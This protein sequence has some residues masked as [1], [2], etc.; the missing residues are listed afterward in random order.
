MARKY[1]RDNRGRFASVGATARGSR[2]KTAGGNKRKSQTI[3]SKASRAGTIG[4]PKGLKPN[5]IK[6][7]QEA[8]AFSKVQFDHAAFMRRSIR[9]DT[10]AGIREAY[11]KQGGRKP[12]ALEAKKIARAKD[13]AARARKFDSTPTRDRVVRSTAAKPATKKTKARSKVSDAKISRVINRVNSVVRG[14]DTKS[15]VKRMNAVE[16]GQRAKSFLARKAGGVSAINGMGQAE[17]FASV[18]KAMTKPPRYS[19]TNPNRNKPGAYNNLGQSSARAKARA[20]AMTPQQR[21][22]QS[23]AAKVKPASVASRAGIGSRALK[24]P[25]PSVPGYVSGRRVGGTIAKRKTTAK[26]AVSS[27][28]ARTRKQATSVQRF[29]RNEVLGRTRGW[30]SRNEG[31]KRRDTGMR[32]LSL[33]GPSKTLYSY[34]P[35]K[36]RRK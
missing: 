1:T 12:T 22:R 15:G 16:V 26:P 9:R 36:L 30:N 14:A 2:L 8:K 11:A 35:T 7:K 6:P 33:T 21:I 17:S 13:T 34:K 27:T 19:T 23:N 25:A 32:Q 24:L 18:R 5:S 31:L 3:Q 20:A 10:A 28:V 29:R 4:K